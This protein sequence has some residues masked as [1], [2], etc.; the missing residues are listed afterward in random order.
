MSVITSGHQ[1]HE[2]QPLTY[3]MDFGVWSEAWP[4]AQV[5]PHKACLQLVATCASG[6]SLGL[7]TACGHMRKWN[8]MKPAYSAW[9]HAQDEHLSSSSMHALSGLR[10]GSPSVRTYIHTQ[11]YATK[12]NDHT[13]DR[14]KARRP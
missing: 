6:T 8:P 13:A 3:E 9:P 10:A 4:H 14:K 1:H 11:V 5:E 7:P 2:K 12:P